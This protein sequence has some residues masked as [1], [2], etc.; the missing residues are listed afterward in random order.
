[1]NSNFRVNYPFNFIA[2]RNCFVLLT[3][4][5]HLFC[6]CTSIVL[7]FVQL[8]AETECWVCVEEWREREMRETLMEEDRIHRSS[9]L[10]SVQGDRLYSCW[11]VENGPFSAISGTSLHGYC[12]RVPELTHFSPALSPALFL[13]GI[14]PV[15]L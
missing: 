14:V 3:Y 2:H 15:L 9:Q 6:V 4:L 1:M 5:R 7:V 10:Q 8:R 12:G 13:C 11:S